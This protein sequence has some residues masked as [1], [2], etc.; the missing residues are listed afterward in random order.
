VKKMSLEKYLK[1]S[2]R[3]LLMRVTLELRVV[4]KT[5]LR[6]EVVLIAVAVNVP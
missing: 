3:R 1:S 4:G 2:K 5:H 6:K